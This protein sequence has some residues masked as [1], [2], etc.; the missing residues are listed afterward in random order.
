MKK[1]YTFDAHPANK[2]PECGTVKVTL[3]EEEMRNLVE[4]YEED[5]SPKGFDV[6][7]DFLDAA[8][9]WVVLIGGGFLFWKMF[10]YVWGLIAG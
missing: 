4:L 9:P 6:V 8:F 5:D 1:T 10:F 2:L 7:I 3:T